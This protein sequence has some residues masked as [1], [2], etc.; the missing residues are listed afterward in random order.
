MVEVQVFDPAMCCSTGVCGPAVDPALARFASDLE[1][2]ASQGASVTRFNLGQEPGAFVSSPPVAQLLQLSGEAALP[3]VM[4]AG[5][6]RSSGRYPERKELAAWAGID[7][8]QEAAPRVQGPLVPVAVAAAQPGC[9][10]DSQQ[11]GCC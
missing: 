7:I 9:G 4:V 10:G 3:A 2:L 5:E 6:V 11:S 8:G 1:W